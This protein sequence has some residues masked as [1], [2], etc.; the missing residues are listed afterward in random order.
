MAAC[1]LIL[2]GVAG[3]ALGGPLHAHMPA[4]QALWGLASLTWLVCVLAVRGRAGPSRRVLLGGALAL[5]LVA[6]SGNPELSDDVHRYVFEGALVAEGRSPYAHAP[7]DPAR[8]EER[9]RW[10]ELA[11]RINHPEVPAAYPPWTQAA[12]AL[13]VLAS[14][15][16]DPLDAARAVT[17][18]RW[19]FAACD[20]LVLGLLLAWLA[21]RGLPPGL[22]LVWGWS[23]LVT[24]EFASS[25]HFD[26]IGIA[27]VVAALG[28]LDRAPGSARRRPREGA[29]G[30]LLAGATLVKLLPV[31][32]APFAW[33]AARS[34]GTLALG[35]AVTIAGS[36][37]ALFSLEDGARGIL[38]GVSEYAFRW[39]A[40]S[41]LHRFVE[42]PLR[43]ALPV[44]EGLTDARRVARLLGGLVFLGALVFAWRARLSLERAALVAFGAFLIL[45]PTLHPWYVAWVLPFLALRPS[46]AFTWLAAA[47]PL[48]Y[49]PLSAWH[50]RGVWHEPAWLWPVVA[51]P[52]YLL[53]ARELAGRRS[54]AGSEGERVA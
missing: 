35:F 15:G 53:L 31:V 21:R 8:A 48:L 22:A 30:A 19:A 10:P 41:L 14:G 12:C 9:A 3:V 25:A 37:L 49:W 54:A 32:L 46:A 20:L 40:A 33:R 18:M 13:L 23:P 4:G 16:T 44:D 29:A 47:V 36:V 5:R 26:V 7:A 51:L 34:R 52:F 6:L 11:A 17:V 1:A 27:L 39:E 24:L 50:E 42:S 45:T 38:G 2:A 43:S 28:L